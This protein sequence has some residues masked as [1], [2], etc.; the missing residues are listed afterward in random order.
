[1]GYFVKSSKTPEDRAM[2]V[3]RLGLVLKTIGWQII[4]FD[5]LVAVWLWIGFRSGSYLWFWWCLGTGLIALTLIW[6]GGRKQQEG[7]RLLA[8]SVRG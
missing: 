3:Q 8:E 5:S 7:E 2:D 6:L 4:A 1:M